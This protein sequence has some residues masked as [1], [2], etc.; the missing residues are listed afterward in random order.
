MY[1]IFISP[2]PSISIVQQNTQFESLKTPN[3]HHFCGCKHDFPVQNLQAVG[4]TT[5]NLKKKPRT[6]RW[7]P[8]TKQADVESRNSMD[9]M[10]C[11]WL[12]RFLFFLKQWKVIRDTRCFEVVHTA[13]WMDLYDLPP[14]LPEQCNVYVGPWQARAT[15]SRPGST[16][17]NLAWHLELS[18]PLVGE[19]KERLY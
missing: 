8:S 10:R 19:C 1:Y 15:N 12:G 9:S 7:V 4:L 13:N 5:G 17:K 14:M 11:D 6:S 3:S 2:N 16:V 18:K